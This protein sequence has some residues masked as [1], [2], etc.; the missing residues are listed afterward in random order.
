MQRA[1]GASISKSYVEQCRSNLD[2][3]ILPV[4]GKVQIDHI[5]VEMLESFLLK[6]IAPDPVR[7][8]AL[9]SQTAN[10][11]FQV[12]R[13]MLKE[14]RRK[15]WITSNPAAKVS[16]LAAHNREHGVFSLEELRRFFSMEA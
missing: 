5:T 16:P 10:N 12:L 8:T 6:L 3:H 13:T 11:I 15:G 1:K 4:F 14:A 9:S 7:N 2:N